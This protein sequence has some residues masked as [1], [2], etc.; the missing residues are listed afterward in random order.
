MALETIFKVK[1]LYSWTFQLSEWG[2]ASM[3]GGPATVSPN[4]AGEVKE[5]CGVSACLSK[6]GMA[7]IT[8]RPLTFSPNE[9]S[10]ASVSTSPRRADVAPE[11]DSVKE[12]WPLHPEEVWLRMSVSVADVW[13]LSP[14][15]HQGSSKS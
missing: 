1:V 3:N 13:T 10:M 8:V 2:V 4:G 15:F 9:G 6:G 11:L 7:Y 5:V 14:L 12:P